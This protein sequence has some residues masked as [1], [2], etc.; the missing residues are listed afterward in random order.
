MNPVA[1][2]ILA[3]L[4]IVVLACAWLAYR[5]RKNTILMA[6]VELFTGTHEASITKLTYAAITQRH[7]LYKVATGVPSGGGFSPVGNYIA[8]TSAINDIPMGTVADETPQEA[9]QT[10]VPSGVSG[11]PTYTYDFEVAVL[12]LGKGSTKRMVCSGHGAGNIVV[13]GLVYTDTGGKVQHARG[14]AGACYQVGVCVSNPPT[15]EDDVLEVADCAPV[16]V[17]L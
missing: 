15:N 5:R 6:N 11:L 3:L 13:G 12:L 14:S 4:A 8:V 1:L 16:A 17:T 9:V 2:S 10:N 7:L